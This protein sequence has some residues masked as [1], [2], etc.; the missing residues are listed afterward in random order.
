MKRYTMIL[1]IAWF[2]ISD[3]IN[4][5][6]ITANPASSNLCIKLNNFS[7]AQIR[8]ITFK[9]EEVMS[10]RIHGDNNIDVSEWNRGVFLIIVIPDDNHCIYSRKLIVTD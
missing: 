2:L 8:I 1:L 9:G 3:G 10:Q 4:A 5:K 6:L 7:S